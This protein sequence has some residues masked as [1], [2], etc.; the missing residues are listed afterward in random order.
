MRTLSLVMLVVALLVLAWSIPDGPLA[1]LRLRRRMVA[2][3]DPD[4][5]PQERAL[6]VAQVREMIPL[7]GQPALARAAPPFPRG[8]DPAELRFDVE[9]PPTPEGCPGLRVRVPWHSQSVPPAAPG[10]SRQ[11]VTVLLGEGR[12]LLVVVLGRVGQVDAGGVMVAARDRPAVTRAL[13][14]AWRPIG[15]VEH[16]D[17][18]AGPAWRHA[19]AFGGKLV[20]DTH[21][22]RDGWAFA[23]GVVRSEGDGAVDGLVDAVLATWQWLPAAAPAASTGPLPDA[24]ADVLTVREPT[25]RA[26]A[27]CRAPAAPAEVVAHGV[28]CPDGAWTAVHL[29]LSTTACLVVTS[30]PADPLRDARTAL[31]QPDRRA[32]SPRVTPT[33]A[34]RERPAPAGTFLTR[35]VTVGGLART[36]ARLDRGGRA[37]RWLLTY[38]PGETGALA[39]LDDV[40]RTWR[41][42]DVRDTGPVRPRDG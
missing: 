41:W 32:W 27:W 39:V 37:W 14:E 23:V 11:P 38:G 31:E 21:V 25:G 5:P 18:A 6:A 16:A 33:A 26:A 35:T 42:A 13:G 34:V 4:L 15:D 29:R 9:E 36:E 8:A 12:A 19:Y 3:L 24:A 30:A 7:R 17:T 2:Q 1:R 10:A 20:T 28:P 40:L 22:D